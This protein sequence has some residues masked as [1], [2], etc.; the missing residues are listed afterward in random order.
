MAQRW[1]NFALQTESDAGLQW[2]VTPNGK[3]RTRRTYGE[4]LTLL[5]RRRLG[6]RIAVPPETGRNRMS[7]PESTSAG[8][9]GHSKKSLIA[10]QYEK[11]VEERAAEL[12]NAV[13]LAAL[14]HVSCGS[15]LE[16]ELAIWH[17]LADTLRGRV[18]NSD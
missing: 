4:R 9:C 7:D 2:I 18:T 1:P 10:A 16:L 12:T 13:Y 3:W 17:V 14:R 5:I 15:W 6:E 8:F 11:W